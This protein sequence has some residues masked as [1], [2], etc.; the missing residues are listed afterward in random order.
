ML[1]MYDSKSNMFSN[2]T[3]LLYSHATFKTY[4]KY[5]APVLVQNLVIFIWLFCTTSLQSG[6]FHCQAEEVEAVPPGEERIVWSPHSNLPVSE[7]C[8]QGSLRGNQE[9]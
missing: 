3:C 5:F 8:P 9:L 2:V 1:L 4:F 7:G 6:Q